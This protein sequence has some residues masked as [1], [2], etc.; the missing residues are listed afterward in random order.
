MYRKLNCCKN[1]LQTENADPSIYGVVLT[2][3][4]KSRMCHVKWFSREGQELRDERDVSVYD[5]TEHTDF[6]FSAGD[7]VV[8]VA[9]GDIDGTAAEGG[10]KPIPC[11][12]QVGCAFELNRLIF[13]R[14]IT[15]PY[16]FG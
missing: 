5:I 12:G 13:H 2:A 1:V 10:D 15:V 9:K 14:Q 4:H 6:V 8:R 16:Y 7:V 11:V 3:D